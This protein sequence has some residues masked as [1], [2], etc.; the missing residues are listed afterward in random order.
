MA[1]RI[2][3]RFMDLCDEPVDHLLLPIKG[4]H[5]QQ[6]VSHNEVIEPVS[7]FFN[8]IEDNV[9]VALHNCQHPTDGLDQQE[10]AAIHLYTMQFDGGP[11]LYQVLHQSL[12]AED[13]R[14]ELSLHGG[15]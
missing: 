10:A 12:R 3:S 8:E 15:V 11:S 9:F 7:Q 14:Q 1:M 13:P 6:L 5:D 4:D 2:Q